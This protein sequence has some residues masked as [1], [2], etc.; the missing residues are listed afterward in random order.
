[1]RIAKA[2]NQLVYW[3]VGVTAVIL[4]LPALTDTPALP[5]KVSEVAGAWSGYSDHRDFVRL[6]FDTNG[7]GYAS[8]TWILPNNPPP[9]VYRITRWRLFEWSIEADIE[10][11]SKTAAPMRFTKLRF[12]F[13]SIECEFGGADWSHRAQLF[14]DKD[15]QA[16]MKRAQREIDEARKKRK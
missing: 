13:L 8:I 15:W 16:Q 1:M 12:G 7:T 9:D 10:V 6:E 11:M 3:V 4:A 5:P 14:S 2:S